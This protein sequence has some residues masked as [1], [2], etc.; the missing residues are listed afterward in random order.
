MKKDK[1]MQIATAIVEE[2][3]KA[4]DDDVEVLGPYEEGVNRVRNLYRI[5]VM[6]RGDTLSDVKKYIYHS[7]IFTQEGLAIDV[8]PM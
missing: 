6:V 1:A 5:S 3:S 7:W 2:L 8:D 4:F